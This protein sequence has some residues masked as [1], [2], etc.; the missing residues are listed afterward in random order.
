MISPTCQTVVTEVFITEL[1]VREHKVRTPSGSLR[2]T[3]HGAHALKPTQKLSG[4]ARVVAGSACTA[5]QVNVVFRLL[6]TMA[7]ASDVQT[8][9]AYPFQSQT[10]Q[11][12]VTVRLLMVLKG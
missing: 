12:A 1:H 9:G 3:V 2:L 11:I 5:H 8:R 7:I 4:S 6:E 10:S